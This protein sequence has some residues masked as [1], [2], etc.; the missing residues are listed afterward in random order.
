VDEAAPAQRQRRGEFVT[1]LAVALAFLG[2][3]FYTYHYLATNPVIPE[4]ETFEHFPDDFGGWHCRGRDVLGEDIIGNLGVS[5]YL[6]CTFESQEPLRII[7]VYVG[8]HESQ[9]REEG[10][11]SGENSIHPPAHCLPGS[12]WDIID[13][14]TVELDLPGLPTRPARVKR[15]MIAR[16]DLRQLTYYWYQSRGRVLSEDWKKV[17]YV[18]LDRAVRSRT[19]GSLVRFT[20]PILRNDEASA[21]EAFRDL[22]PRVLAALPPHVPE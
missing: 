13:N 7:G 22:A 11:G 19:D 6:S 5:D 10:G 15:M 1:R 16:G 8:Y 18:G 20:I 21:D 17:L 12:G 9:V 4:R 2:F 14:Q 3:N